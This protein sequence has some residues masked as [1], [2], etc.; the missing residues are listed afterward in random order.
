MVPLRKPDDWY[1]QTTLEA[2]DK[3]D[4]CYMGHLLGQS[5]GEFLGIKLLNSIFLLLEIDTN[6]ILP[7]S[8]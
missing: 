5:C 7:M 6:L 4:H 2:K 1:S 8:T 3:F